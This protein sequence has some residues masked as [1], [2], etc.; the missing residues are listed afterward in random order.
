MHLLFVLLC[1]YTLHIQVWKGYDVVNGTVSHLVF[2][3]GD[4]CAGGKQRSAR[5][6]LVCGPANQ[7]MSAS[8]PAPCEYVTPFLCA[9]KGMVC[10][11]WGQGCRETGV[12]A[13]L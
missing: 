5:V 4:N 13:K 8:E 3:H 2:E 1:S 6:S 7:T 11:W 9:N 12:V 10:L